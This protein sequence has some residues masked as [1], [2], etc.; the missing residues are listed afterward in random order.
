VRL[1]PPVTVR[2]GSWLSVRARA[3]AIAVRN[4]GRIGLSL[5][6][7]NSHEYKPSSFLP[8]ACRVGRRKGT[9]SA[10]AASERLPN[11]IF[12]LTDDQRWDALGV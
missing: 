6:S 9:R 11:I 8:D 12:L 1:H 3:T 2:P 5:N 10:V 7:R 4:E